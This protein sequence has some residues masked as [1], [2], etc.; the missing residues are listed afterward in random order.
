MTV[1]WNVAPRY[2]AG[3]PAMVDEAT[4]R[5]VA[6]QEQDAIEAFLDG[7]CGEENRTKAEKLGLDGIVWS[8]LEIRR[9]LVTEDL[10]TGAVIKHPIRNDQEATHRAGRDRI[11]EIYRE[12]AQIEA[13]S[14]ARIESLRSELHAIDALVGASG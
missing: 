8:S 13:E 3:S 9:V 11:A 14:A 5:R 2:T 6:A 4:A 12:I 10:I 1:T 7:S